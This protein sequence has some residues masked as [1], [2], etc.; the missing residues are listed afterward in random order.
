MIAG[1][2]GRCSTPRAEPASRA[3]GQIPVSYGADRYAA[4]QRAH[5]QFRWFGGG[6]KVNAELLGPP[7]F[8]AAS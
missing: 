5:E 6:W 7:A 2:W 3:W 8:E 4:V 1:G